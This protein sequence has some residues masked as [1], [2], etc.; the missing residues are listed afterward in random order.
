MHAVVHEERRTRQSTLVQYLR[1][2]G[3][4]PD[5]SMFPNDC[6]PY[7]A[8]V[9]GHGAQLK[10]L[11]RAGMLPLGRLR[12]RQRQR[13]AGD[14]PACGGPEEDAVHFVFTCGALHAVRDQL[15]SRLDN[16]THGAFGQLMYDEPLDIVLL[17]L[18]GDTYWGTDALAVDSCVRSFL[19]VAAWA[20]REA[21]VAAQG[22]AI[23]HEL[24]PDSEPV[25]VPGPVRVRMPVPVGGAVGA[26]LGAGERICAECHSRR[27]A[28]DMLQCQ[29]CL[30]WFHRSC[31]GVACQ[32]PVDGW[33]CGQCAVVVPVSPGGSPPHKRRRQRREGPWRSR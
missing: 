30:R 10:F 16:I 12:S 13:S 11:M 8:G 17:G 23:V 32:V 31:G 3:P 29:A 21:A 7:L 33:V 4:V 19:L 24:E 26:V 25:H 20:A 1:L 28:G 14:C 27:R 22:P 5:G 15:Y 9:V 2:I 18:L 6:R